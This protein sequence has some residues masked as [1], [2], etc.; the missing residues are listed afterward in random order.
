MAAA[1]DP[2]KKIQNI[3]QENLYIFVIQGE[4]IQS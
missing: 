3:I 2:N 4:K 1:N